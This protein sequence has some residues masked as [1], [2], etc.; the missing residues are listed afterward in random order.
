M[1]LHHFQQE[2]TLHRLMEEYQNCSPTVS[3][4]E[5]FELER[6]IVTDGEG[7]ED[8]DDEDT[9]TSPGISNPQCVSLSEV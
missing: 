3:N 8:E 2:Q 4:L 7:D 9:A 5:P 1:F 6:L